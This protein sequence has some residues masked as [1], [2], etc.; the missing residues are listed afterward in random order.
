MHR[1]GAKLPEDEAFQSLPPL[2]DV[3]ARHG[4]KARRAL[5]QNFLLDSNLTRRIV[6]EAGPFNGATIIEVGPGP[7]GLTRALLESQAVQI[8]AIERDRRCIAALEELRILFPDRLT[9]IEDNALKS[10]MAGIASK[11]SGPCHIV[12]N[13]PYNIATPLLTGW[14]RDAGA[15]ASMT[16]MFQKEVADRL[17]AAP[18]NSSYS[19]LSIITQ[20]LCDVRCLFDVP[21][22]AFVPAPKVTSTVVRLVPRPAPLAEAEMAVLELVTAA[23]FGQRRKMLRSALRTIADDPETLLLGAGIAPTARA[24]TLSV[25]QFCALARNL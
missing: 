12:A 22:R 2:R 10:N 4:L 21:P 25:E 3:I 11:A 20:W 5:G 14:L 8:I 1:A 18:G 15:F 16:L 24:E 9:L 19:R 17:A 13:L 23:A 6:R 7:G